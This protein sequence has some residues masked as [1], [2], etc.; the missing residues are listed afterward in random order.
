MNLPENFVPAWLRLPT[1]WWISI[2][3]GR[4]HH[5]K[6][7][8]TLQGIWHNQAHQPGRDPMKR[9]IACVQQHPQY[10]GERP[11]DHIFQFAAAQWPCRR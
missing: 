5:P 4:N 11:V 10:A 1:W 9:W 7:S 3:G 6:G 8:A 2:R